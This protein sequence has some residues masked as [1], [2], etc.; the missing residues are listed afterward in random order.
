[1]NLIP[2]INGKLKDDVCF[3]INE[4]ITIRNELFEERSIE[5]FSI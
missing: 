5:V 4:T 2:K 3:S 1:M